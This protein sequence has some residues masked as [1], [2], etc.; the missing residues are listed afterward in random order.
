MRILP[1]G[2]P[3][4][5]QRRRPQ[6]SDQPKDFLKQAPWDRYLGQLEGDI[7]A[8][9]DNFGPDLAQLL[10]QSGQRPVL[11]LFGVI[12][13][14]LLA[15][16]R[17]A[18][19]RNRLP[20]FPQQRTFRSPRWT[21]ACDPGCVKTPVPRPS[22]QQLNPEGNVGESLLRLRPPSRINISSWSPQNSFYTAWVTNGSPAWTTECPVLGVKR[23][24]LAR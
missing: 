2:S 24:K 7:P 12:Q 3:S 19:A 22:A 13:C 10:A 14:R 9:A 4:W 5:R 6:F 21:S 8:M 1:D 20:L 16:R 18:A 23:T 17:H 11:D 15:T